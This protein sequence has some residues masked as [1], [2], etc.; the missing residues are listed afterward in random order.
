MLRL[1]GNRVLSTIPVM[2]VVAV[3]VFLLLHLSQGDPAS[4]IAGD[5]ASETEIASIRQRLGLDAPIYTQFLRWIGNVLRGD[6]GTSIFTNVPVATLIA[7]RLEPTLMLA[8]TTTLFSICAALPLGIAAALNF[9]NWADRAIMILAVAAFSLPVFVTGYALIFSFSLTWPIFPVQGY[10][11]LS[12]GIVPFLRHIALPT[13]SLGLIYTALLARMT[14]ATFLDVMGQDYIRTAR[15]KGLG[16]A[17]V[18][19]VHALKNA[20]IPIVTTIGAG[21]AI[22]IGGVVVTEN[23]FAIPGIGRLTVEALLRRDY[24]VIQG[25]ILTFSFIYVMINLLIDIAYTVLDPRIR[26]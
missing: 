14:R 11:P 21:L 25:V 15:A 26:Y 23:V 12:S 2:L 8:A 19:L 1:I 13:L 18:I 22:L 16:P 4:I 9:G 7:Q 10:K 17:R 5:F 3:I 6:L 24:P 20:S